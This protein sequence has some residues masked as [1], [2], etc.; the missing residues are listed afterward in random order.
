[1]KYK[2]INYPL[3]RHPQGY[4]HNS[5]TDLDQIKSD[6][7]SVILTKAGERV[8]EAF[9]I[10]WHLVN[11]NQPEE[12]IRQQVR[13]MIAVA[14]VRNEP[15]IQVE[16]IIIEIE[17]TIIKSINIIFQDPTNPNNFENLEINLLNGDI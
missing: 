10:N 17:D 5:D 16:D 14:L 9:G 8:H 12:A 11:Y 6:M 2:G 15:R 3:I 1:M 13:Q 4:L 7:L